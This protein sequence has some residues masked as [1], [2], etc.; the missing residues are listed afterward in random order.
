MKDVAAGASHT[1]VVLTS[2]NRRS[3]AERL[4]DRIGKQE[5]DGGSAF[6]ASP[7]RTIKWPAEIEAVDSP[8]HGSQTS[9]TAGSR[10]RNLILFCNLIVWC[11]LLTISSI[12]S[13]HQTS[14]PEVFTSADE[15]TTEF[16]FGGST[17]EMPTL[18]FRGID[19]LGN[20]AQELLIQ[21]GWNKA[22]N[23]FTAIDAS[24]DDIQ[25]SVHVR[26]KNVDDPRRGLA[27]IRQ[28]NTPLG[29]VALLDSTRLD[30]MTYIGTA[31]DIHYFLL[32]RD[33][34]YVSCILIVVARPDPSLD[35]SNLL[36]QNF[37]CNT[38]FKL[39][40]DT[41]AW[42]TTFGHLT[43]VGSSFTAAHRET[44]SLIR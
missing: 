39:P 38:V 9:A 4:L 32:D 23:A 11:G 29:K 2:W 20:D 40:H 14:R 30:G 12:A 28:S 7:A 19:S 27:M 43:H 44:L 25:L 6:N 31:R 24:S 18:F 37:S 41:Y 13:A 22:T 17:W 1:T 10:A 35:P 15:R 26:T 36:L 21:F 16:S 5:S 3:I 33:D 34:A 42:V 8:A